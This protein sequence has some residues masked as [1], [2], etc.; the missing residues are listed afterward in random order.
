[1]F[2]YRCGS[3]LDNYGRCY[4]CAEMNS[5]RPQAFWI[6]LFS[7]TTYYLADLCCGKVGFVC[8]S[9]NNSSSD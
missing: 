3:E 4:R 2:C 6:I 1:M 5:M 7:R 8:D 9:G